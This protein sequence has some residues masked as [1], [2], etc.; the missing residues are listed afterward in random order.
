MSENSLDYS[1]ILCDRDSW[2]SVDKFHIC[3]PA[4]AAGSHH[5]GHQP[6]A[7]PQGW[8]ERADLCPAR[9]SATPWWTPWRGGWPLNSEDCVAKKDRA[10]W[11]CVKRLH[12]N[13]EGITRFGNFK[14]T[15]AGTH[16]WHE[17]LLGLLP[18]L[19][20]HLHLWQNTVSGGLELPLLRLNLLHL[21][22]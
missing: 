18:L 11:N 14:D 8:A 5:W 9:P 19:L 22:H 7:G 6:A 3:W 21:I 1:L 2:A 15:P 4:E 12:T 17:R 16:L 20:Q 13:Q 10:M